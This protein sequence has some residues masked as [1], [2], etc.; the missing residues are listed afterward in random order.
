M[1]LWLIR[2]GR[3]GEREDQALDHGLAMV[4]W[5]E[6]PDLS[7][8]RERDDLTR[9]LAVT[10][11]DEGPGTLANW[12]GQLW[13]FLTQMAAG[14]LVALPLRSR[15]AIAVGRV[16]G[17]YVRR[18]DLGGGPVHARPVEWQGELPRGAFDRDLLHALGAL[19]QVA[20]IQR[21]QAEARVRALIEGTSGASGESE[22]PV[23]ALDA[24]AD[25]EQL[26]RDQIRDRLTRGFTGTRLV[27]LVAAV[28]EARGLRVRTAPEGP[29]GPIDIVAGGGP[30]GFDAPRVAVTVRAQPAKVKELRD[31]Q[32]AVKNFGAEQGLFVAMGGYQRTTLREAARRH[33]ALRLWDAD[34]LVAAIESAYD[35]LPATI[36]AELPLKRIWTLVPGEV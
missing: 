13:P 4:G 9:L 20:P 3:F 2:A 29:E 8:V 24:P 34:D 30:L 5:P 23:Q 26:A 35:H 27:G 16:R 33:F 10:Y 31:F 15:S 21:P 17:P 1:T 25:L 11:P 6:L 7:T 36:R 28:L 12:E 18:V 14:D 32:G 19:T 22:A